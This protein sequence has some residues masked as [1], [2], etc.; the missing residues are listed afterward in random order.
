MVSVASL[1]SVHARLWSRLPV[2]LLA[3]A[4]VLLA[5]ASR[6]AASACRTPVVRAKRWFRR[7]SWPM[8]KKVSTAPAF[9]TACGSTAPARSEM[10][11]SD[12]PT[13]KG[14]TFSI[15]AGQMVALVGP[16]GAG[17]S[18]LVKLLVGL[19]QPQ[20]GEILVNNV[21]SNNI[22]MSQLRNQIS[23]VTQDTQLFAGTIKE[24][25]AFVAPEIGRAHV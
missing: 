25:L 14:I 23:F 24:N 2:R 21:N 16:S 15:P 3:Y 4:M 5:I 6:A 17:K 8:P 20:E 19:Y 1:R 9:A 22:D 11:A 10:I 18:T 12:E 7:A 13:L